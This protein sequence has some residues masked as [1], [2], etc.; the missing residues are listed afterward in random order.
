MV[1]P[2]KIGLVPGEVLCDPK[3]ADRV[4]M[5]HIGSWQWLNKQR[6]QQPDIQVGIYNDIKTGIGRRGIYTDIRC[7]NHGC[8]VPIPSNISLNC[9]IDLEVYKREPILS[10]FPAVTAAMLLWQ[11]AYAKTDLSTEDIVVDPESFSGILPIVV[12]AAA[13]GTVIL[14]SGMPAMGIYRSVANLLQ[15]NVS[16]KQQDA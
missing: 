16:T 1:K 5:L 6:R 3:F 2:V 13:R 7:G 4:G 12:A 8:S 9:S 10:I 11:R 14:T 15:V